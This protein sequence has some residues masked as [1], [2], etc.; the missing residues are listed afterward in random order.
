MIRT[1]AAGVVQVVLNTSGNPPSARKPRCG[2]FRSRRRYGHGNGGEYVLTG[3]ESL[4][5]FEQVA[6]IGRVI[7]R[8]LCIEYARGLAARNAEFYAPFVADYLLD[9]WDAAIGQPAFVTS[10]VAKITGEPARTFLDWD[11]YHAAEF[12]T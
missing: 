8:P 4:S 9:A 2:E 5:Q 3:P 12:R 1:E 10:A 6:N 7:G 11:T